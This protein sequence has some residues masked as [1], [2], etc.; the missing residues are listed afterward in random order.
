MRRLNGQ[1]RIDFVPKKLAENENEK[2][3]KRAYISSPNRA[4]MDKK[5]I[6]FGKNGFPCRWSK[7]GLKIRA[8]SCFLFALSANY[9]RHRHSAN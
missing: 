9:M 5:K 2:Y 7:K 1:I 6:Q 4:K 8:K 3:S